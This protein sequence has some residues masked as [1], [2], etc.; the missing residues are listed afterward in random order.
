MKC[1]RVAVRFILRGC[2]LRLPGVQL[3]FLGYHCRW[4]LISSLNSYLRP[5]WKVRTLL[6]AP[7]CWWAAVQINELRRRLKR[8]TVPMAET[9]CLYQ[10]PA[11]ILRVCVFMSVC[12]LTV[13]NYFL[14]FECVGV[15]T[16]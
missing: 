2:S 11:K 16:I 13:F 15:A 1:H 9:M 3:C 6:T 7:L 8:Y 12:V 5:A 4:P 14:F 10:D